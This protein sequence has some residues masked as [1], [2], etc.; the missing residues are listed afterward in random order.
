MFDSDFLSKLAAHVS[1]EL[2]TVNPAEDRAS[3]YAAQLA[4]ILRDF[5]RDKGER[6]ILTLITNATYITRASS[7]VVEC[8]FG[9]RV[10]YMLFLNPLE[11][12]KVA[13]AERA[14]AGHYASLRRDLTEDWECL[15]LAVIRQT[16][17]NPPYDSSVKLF[18]GSLFY[19]GEYTVGEDA[20]CNRRLY[21]AGVVADP[22]DS[23]RPLKGI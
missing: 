22:V 20:H 23:D 6:P 2:D 11:L 15:F 10:V 14:I 7:L 4:A 16:L 3:Y 21:F 19:A 17:E 12:D 5:L 1:K 13:L 9:R 18:G 8:T